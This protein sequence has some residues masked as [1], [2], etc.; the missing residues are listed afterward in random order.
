VSPNYRQTDSRFTYLDSGW[1]IGNRLVVVG[2][3]GFEWFWA[4]YTMGSCE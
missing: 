4:D 1:V 3:M 2:A